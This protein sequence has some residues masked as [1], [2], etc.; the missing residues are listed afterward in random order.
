[1][2]NERE[3]FKM[4]GMTDSYQNVVVFLKLCYLQACSLCI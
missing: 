3:F 2:F 4:E 1:M